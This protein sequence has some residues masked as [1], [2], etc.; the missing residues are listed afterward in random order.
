MTDPADLG[1]SQAADLDTTRTRPR[2]LVLALLLGV[3]AL[4][5]LLVGAIVLLS[6]AGTLWAVADRSDGPSMSMSSKLA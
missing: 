3:L 5:W 6:M 4:V 1:R 2:G